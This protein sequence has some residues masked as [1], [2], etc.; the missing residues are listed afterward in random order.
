MVVSKMKTIKIC[1]V[2]ML[3]LS[4]YSCSDINKNLEEM[5]PSD[6]RGVVRIYVKS[7]VE[8]GNL[9]DDDGNISFPQKLKDL[10]NSSDSSPLSDAI[11]LLKKISI[12]TDGC[13]YCFMP[14]STF[15]FATLV[16]VN[17]DDNAKNEIEKLTG[18]KFQKIGKVDF[19][20]NGST[21]YAIDDDYVFIGHEE[22]ETADENLALTAQS[23]L[24]KSSTG[25]ADDNDITE[26]LHKENDV[27][28]YFNMKGIQNMVSNSESLTEWTKKIPIVTLF[29]DSDIK[30]LTFHMNFEKEGAKFEAYIKADAQSD[31][32]KL[33]DAT[34]AKADA[35]FLKV[36]PTSMNYIVSMSLNG[37]NL[38]KLDQIRK[39]VNL[40]SNLP[41]M[42]KLDFRSIVSAI[43]GP[44]AIA[45][46]A[47]DGVNISSVAN[48][49]W[50]IAIAAKTKNA[51]EIV[52]RIV[53]FA[54][55]MGQEDYMK[56]GRHLF[57]YE[58][59]PVYLGQQDSIVYA[60]RLD[61]ELEEDFYYDVPDVRER[62]TSCPIGFYAKIADPN[63]E[64]YFN[65]GFKN[66]TDGE[67]MFYSMHN[68]N[69][70]ITF[71][72][73]LCQ[74]NSQTTDNSEQYN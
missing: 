44:I 74:S 57:S 18:Q 8:K 14:K 9:I 47:G 16:A 60:I 39:S 64:S 66:K 49:N 48:D 34:M 63:G 67:G 1:L 65:F 7:V 22:K 13:I 53:S 12:D 3:S 5:I 54:A 35:S 69:P 58:G 32:L 56:N 19:L 24:H 11:S 36:I 72:E 51:T 70:V 25:I 61:H 37:E 27:N 52:N 59:M 38:M 73:I 6:S 33:L 43:D 71:L 26:A 23:I 2:L 46:S 42:D 68:E 55:V 17:D 28:A 10:I 30:A 29:T 62:F 4:I 40:L 15:N 21:S 31:Y 50:N 20:R 41:A 45:L